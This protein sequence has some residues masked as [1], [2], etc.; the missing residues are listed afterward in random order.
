MLEAGLQNSIFHLFEHHLHQVIKDQKTQGTL[1]TGAMELRA[2]RVSVLGEPVTVYEDKSTGARCTSVTLQ[3]DRGVSF[4]KALELYEEALEE[5]AES[6]ASFWLA[7]REQY[8]HTNVLLAL[9]KL[10]APHLVYVTRPNTGR[11]PY[12]QDEDEIRHAYQRLEDPEDAREAWDTLY[13]KTEEHCVHGPNCKVGADCSS[14]SRRQIVGMVTGAV[15]PVFNALESTITRF[16][17]NLTKAESDL[18]AV[19]AQLTPDD[20]DDEEEPAPHAPAAE[21]TCLVGIR[22]PAKKEIVADLKKTI[23]ELLVLQGAGGAAGAAS[24]RIEPITPVDSTMFKKAT[25]AK[26]TIASY[27]SAAPSSK[28]PK[29]T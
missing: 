7:R 24:S 2:T 17:V 16:R 26:R 27:F 13:D 20:D 9:P 3:L 5:D 19:R 22:F 12:E 28:K 14:G 10:T 29:T 15:V 21:G 25:E 11:S 8:G 6:R 23:A 18:R 4:D 1:D